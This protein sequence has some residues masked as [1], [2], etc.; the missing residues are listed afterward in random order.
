MKARA[1]LS[2][3]AVMSAAFA[4]ALPAQKL[5]TNDRWKQCAMVIDPSLTQA[6]WHQFVSEVGLVVYYRPLTSAK[7]LGRGNVE[8]DLVNWATRIDDADAA[9]ND[10]FSHPDSLHWLFEGDALKIPAL[11]MRVGVTQR[12]DVGG[13]FTKSIGANYGMYGAEVQYAFLDD[14][15]HNV[16]AAARVNAVQLFGPADLSAGVYGMD[17]VVSKDLKHIAP[18]AGISGFLSRGQEHSSK[19][20]LANESVLGAQ[21][22]LGAAARIKGLRLGAEVNLA[23]VPGYSFKVGF[24]SR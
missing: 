13:Y 24:G 10:T 4:S 20:N 1:L 21:A 3:A 6:A 18:Y 19:V 23:R 8:F 17:V 15:E 2:V 16:T 14:A 22:M 12:I 11:M 9:W 7:P 5:H